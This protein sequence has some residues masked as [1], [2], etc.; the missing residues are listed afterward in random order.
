MTSGQFFRTVTKSGAF[1]YKNCQW[2]SWLKSWL[3]VWVPNLERQKCVLRNKVI[4]LLFRPTTRDSGFI[5]KTR[6][7]KGAFLNDVTQ[8]LRI[9][10]PPTPPSHA[11]MAIL[12]TT[13][14]R[15]SQKSGP[16]SPLVAWRHLWMFPKYNIFVIKSGKYLV[17]LAVWHAF[18]AFVISGWLFSGTK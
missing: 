5:H 8:I 2:M 12:L 16:P 10:D 1:H 15:L 18:L 9:S 7:N 13:L 14:F 3:K 4:L 11:E 6:A 17:M